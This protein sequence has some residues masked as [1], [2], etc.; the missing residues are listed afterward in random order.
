MVKGYKVFN[1]DWKCTPNKDISFQYEVGKR[2]KHS[3]EV[4]PCQ[5]G[6]HFCKKLVDCFNYYDFDPTNKVA[7]IIAHGQV[8]DHENDKSVTDDI[9]IIKE[10]NWFEVLSLVNTGS[11][12]TGKC[13]SGNDNS[14]NENSGYRNSGN[15]NSGHNNS[16][17]NNSG[18][19]NSGSYN[20]GNYNSGNYNSGEFNSGNYNSGNY[21]S[22]NYNSSNYNSG[23]FCRKDAPNII[24]DK[25]TLITRNG[26]NNTFGYLF[27]NLVKTEY[28]DEKLIEYTDKEMWSNWFK[29]KTESE[30]IH[31]K[32]IPNFN[33]E[34][35]FEITGIQL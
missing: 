9:E 16:G 15:Y 28:K 10:L 26:F 35:F 30:I 19:R 12:N 21:N 1:A 31:L 8:I 7:E 17:H 22:G 24:F 23:F 4:I 5:S 3:G 13:N 6:F 33:T 27:K 20:S 34:D 14:G 18:Y 32:T 2:Y 25:E 29:T 11:N